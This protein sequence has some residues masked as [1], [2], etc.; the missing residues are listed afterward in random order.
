MQV[1]ASGLCALLLAGG[2]DR[3]LLF[4]PGSARVGDAVRRDTALDRDGPPRDRD[5]DTVR[6]DGGL[7]DRGLTDRSGD[8]LAPDPPIYASTSSALHRLELATSSTVLIGTF[9]CT[10][11]MTDIAVDQQ[12]K[13]M[14]ISQTAIHTIDPQTAACQMLG[15]LPDS[16]FNSLSFAFADSDPTVELLLAATNAGDFYKVDRTAGILQLISN[17]GVLFSGDLVSIKGVGTFATVTGASDALAR[18]NTDTGAAT[19]IGE[20]GFSKVWA[21]PTCGAR[22][23]ASRATTRSSPSIPRPARARG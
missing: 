20:T 14:G 18:I 16:S 3:L 21:S 19:K 11:Q 4:R 12:G 8:V 10:N 7:S 6:D 15:P 13:M 17:K 22:S 9:S 1:V 5:R 23:T 2:C